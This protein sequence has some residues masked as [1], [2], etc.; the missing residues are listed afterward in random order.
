V[1][2]SAFPRLAAHA[3]ALEWVPLRRTLARALGAVVVLA[4]PALLAL[5]VLGR[6]VIHVLFEHGRFHSGAGALTY[7]VLVPYALGLPAYVATEVLVRG[8]ISLRDTRTPLLT[9]SLQ[10]VGRAVLLAVLVGRIGVIAIP[11]AF[12]VMAAAE[13]VLL[14]VVL[15]YTLRRVS[16]RVAAPPPLV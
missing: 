15:L 5:I 16:R 10:I 14:G 3:A 6:P 7:R 12:A 4:I 2:Q 1:G 9:N 13:S 11:V 8:L